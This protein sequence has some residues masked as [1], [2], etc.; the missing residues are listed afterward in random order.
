MVRYLNFQCS[1]EFSNPVIPVLASATLGLTRAFGACII[2]G[3]T[4]RLHRGL[5]D[6]P[7]LLAKLSRGHSPVS[8]KPDGFPPRWRDHLLLR[9]F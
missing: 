8:A 1:R 5:A 6:Q 9:A 4:L 7:L 2:Y 3:Y